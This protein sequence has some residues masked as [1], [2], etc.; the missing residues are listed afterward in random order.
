MTVL[1]QI[2]ALDS[3]E[4]N[5][6]AA[7][8]RVP[9]TGTL[10]ALEPL[11]QR[12][13][14]DLRL[15]ARTSDWSLMP[16]DA[17]STE[18]FSRW[19]RWALSTISTDPAARFAVIRRDSGRAIGSSTFH[20]L[21]PE[22]RRVEIGMTWYARGEWGSGANVEAKLLM[23]EHAFALGF[24]RVEFKTDARNARSRRAL[25]ALPA[26]FEGVMRKHML[27]RDGQRRDSAYYAV[28]DDDW[29]DVRANLER[30]LAS[31]Q[32]SQTKPAAK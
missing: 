10:V 16:I 6:A 5:V 2:L 19:F 14:H 27:V 31:R 20:T 7:A 22:H 8:L 26:Q 3:A 25:E 1:A 23:L 15:A 9:L 11:E 24:H 17:T 4:A 12:H 28:T 30:R 21:H 18:G 32:A 29:Q 13:E